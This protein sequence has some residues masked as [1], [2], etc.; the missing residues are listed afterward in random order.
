MTAFTYTELIEKAQSYTRDLDDE[1]LA[2]IP[3]LISR[4][5]N[6]CVRVLDLDVLDET[7]TATLSATEASIPIPID[8]LSVRSVHMANGTE[9]FKR[10][11]TV[12]K[13]L[14]AQ[15]TAGD[16]QY[17]ADSTG[18]SISVAPNRPEDGETEQ[19]ELHY[20]PDV[21]GLSSTTP[22]TWISTHLG[23]LLLTSLLVA[24]EEYNKNQQA[25]QMR[26]AVFNA[27]L[28][29]LPSELRRMVRR[30][31]QQLEPSSTAQ[32]P[33]GSGS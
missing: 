19:V 32:Q 13:L 16:P 25:M 30:D 12:L 15:L 20:V 22:T 8:V 1:F 4:A 21:V 6:E 29:S 24:I 28:T 27:Q 10:S 33:F 9:L 3:E 17:W 18:A 26:A 7:T 14:Q 5:E 2:Q 11:Y 23:D 31:Y